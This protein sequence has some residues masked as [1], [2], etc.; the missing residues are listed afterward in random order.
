ML[1][2]IAG[3]SRLR[4]VL[5]LAVMLVVATAAHAS[6]S[7]SRAT[8]RSGPV[9]A[10]YV[11]L[12]DSYSAGEGLGGFEKGTDID[13]GTGR[14]QCHRSAKDAYPVLRPAVVL[15][16]VTSRAFY[17]CSGATSKDM[18][19]LPPQKGDGRQVGQPQQTATVGPQTQYITLSAGGNDV[20][21]GD[22]GL[23]CVEIVINHRKVYRLSSTSCKDQVR[24]SQKKLAGAQAS[25]EK[26][27]TDLLAR[28]PQATI[29]VVG[30]PRVLPAAYKGVPTLK[31]SA[32]CVLDHYP[33]PLATTDIG[34]PVAQAKLLDQFTVSLNSAIQNAV[35]DVRRTHPQQQAQLRYADSY[36]SSVPHNC[37]GTTPNA[38][39]TAAQ[40]SLGHGLSGQSITD[41]LKK[42]WIATST[43]HPT[44]AG[45]RLFATLVQQA[46]SSSPSPLTTIFTR[47]TPVTDTAAITPG[48]NVVQ[49]FPSGNCLE[50]SEVGQ[51][52]RCFTDHY[53]LDPCYAVA[54]P[55]TGDGTGVVCPESPFTT[56]LDAIGSA[57]G[58]GQLDTETFDE[59]NG[60]VLANGARCFEAQGAHGAADNGRIIDYSCDDD[61]TAILRG[62][63]E[64]LPL[65]SADVG[66]VGVNQNV[67]ATGNLPIA[68]AVLLLHQ[69]PPANRPVT[70][71]GNA[72]ADELDASARMHHEVD[73]GEEQTVARSTRSRQIYD[74]GA[75]CYDAELIVTE[76]D[77]GDALEPGWSCDTTDDL[78]LLC[79][80][81]QDPEVTDAP[82]FF[83]A[84]HIRAQF[85][86]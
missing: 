28:A 82:A 2:A 53:V 3:R 20:G 49:T 35:A 78:T 64:T 9:G 57:T 29:V 10:A 60:I 85:V 52:Y 6:A 36:S 31:G 17:A 44:K 25:L 21:F 58:L 38:T 79:E 43:L 63:H 4:W 11:A 30:Y 59:P 55:V 8:P 33:V 1:M 75:P 73:C 71:A 41:R 48:F 80:K 12:G 14:N 70:D 50:G 34:M 42:L 26:L 19:S 45:Q 56:D 69:V 54:E 23:G 15:P 81:D 24:A 61:R 66:A 65:W 47:Q 32:F 51:A 16:Q 84:A 27:Y 74:S 77:N 67:T 7:S 76:W 46:F 40:L 83:A 62:L 68:S 5:L 39:V 22:L 37:K 13:K 18:M 72:T 86:G